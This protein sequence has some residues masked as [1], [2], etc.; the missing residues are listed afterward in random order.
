ML[1]TTGSSHRYLARRKPSKIRRLSRCGRIQP[2][3]QRRNNRLLDGHKVKGHSRDRQLK[4]QA[5]SCK[6]QVRMTRRAS[7]RGQ[8]TTTD[9]VAKEE[10]DNLEVRNRRRPILKSFH[11]LLVLQARLDPI[12][13]QD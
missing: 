13:E 8:G 12:E 9:L 7:S 5:S 4:R 11:R 6:A 1:V 10:L 3:E 2:S